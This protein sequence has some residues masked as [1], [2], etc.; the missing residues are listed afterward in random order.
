ML[1]EAIAQFEEEGSRAARLARFCANCQTLVDGLAALGFKPL[2]QPAVQ[3]PI[4][5]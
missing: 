3:A 5:A 1:H 4:I 2:L